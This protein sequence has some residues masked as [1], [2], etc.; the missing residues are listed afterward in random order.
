M[1]HSASCCIFVFVMKPCC[2]DSVVNNMHKYMLLLTDLVVYLWNLSKPNAS[3]ATLNKSSINPRTDFKLSQFSMFC[4]NIVFN[5][6]Y[7]CLSSSNFLLLYI[8]RG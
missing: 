6:L 8:S 5:I 4:I 7:C 1:F 3:L 2:R